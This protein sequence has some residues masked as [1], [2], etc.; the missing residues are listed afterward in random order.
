MSTEAREGLVRAMIEII[1]EHGFEQL[2]VRSV[3]SRAGVSGGAVQ[4]HFPT[5]S[6]MLNAAMT[7]ITSLAAQRT[8]D[9]GSVAD[10]VERLHSLVD[11]L[12]PENEANRVAR[13]WLAFAARASVDEDIRNAYVK[14]WGRLRN[15]LRVLI[16]AAGGEPGGAEQAAR[17]L[18]ALV[19]GLALSVITEQQ[20]SGVARHIAHIRL[21]NLISRHD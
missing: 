10:P 21:D 2:S 20:D 6:A 12:I 9:L 15:E 5:K 4:H 1:A 19:D 18:L 16:T 11:L 7:A 14:L 8:S 13:V 3:A 17:E